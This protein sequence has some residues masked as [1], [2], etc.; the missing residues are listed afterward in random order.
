MSRLKNALFAAYV[1]EAKAALRLKVFAEVAE[2][3]GFPQIARL[4]RA[5]GFSEEIHGGRMLRLMDDPGSTEENLRR[6]FDSESTI[7]GV[8]YNR[9]IQLAMAEEDEIAT[10][11]FTHCR[12]TEG[13]HA[14]L[15]K[16]AMSRLMEEQESL[17]YHVCRICGHVAPG[18]APERCPV[19]NVTRDKFVEV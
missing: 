7:A 6:S 11:I 8:A 4:F 12:D 17:C 1:G 15:Y 19:C 5:I 18:D 16:E 3:E 2:K 9:F 13:Y 10:R 14:Q